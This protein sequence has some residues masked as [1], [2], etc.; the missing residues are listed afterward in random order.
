MEKRRNWNSR[1]RMKNWGWKKKKRKN[2]KSRKKMRNWN[3]RKKRN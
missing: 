1:K 2:W 3:R